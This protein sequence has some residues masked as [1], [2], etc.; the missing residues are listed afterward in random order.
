[1]AITCKVTL[2]G[3]DLYPELPIGRAPV[4]IRD[5]QR[6]LN[7]QLRTA[8][9]ASKYTFTLSLSDAT[10]AERAAWLA[11]ASVTASV[12]YIDELNVSRTVVVQDVSDPLS[13]TVPLVDG[14][15]ST[16]GDGFYDLSIQLE[17]V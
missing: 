7:G 16:T 3:T 14:S 4:L 10:E 13:R 15:L 5:Q 17:E 8:H 2:N 12:T 9:R 1:M 11:A 6:M